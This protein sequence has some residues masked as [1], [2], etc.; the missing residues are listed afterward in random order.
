M[1]AAFG[2]L[3]DD[4]HVAVIEGHGL[5]EHPGG[6]GREG[7]FAREHEVIGTEDAGCVDLARHQRAGC[8]SFT[9]DVVTVQPDTDVEPAHGEVRTRFEAVGP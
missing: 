9:S 1:A 4:R 5:R 2:V 6:V 3:V 8:V 7:S